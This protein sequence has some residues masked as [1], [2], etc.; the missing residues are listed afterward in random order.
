VILKHK[1][2]T[3]LDCAF[4]ALA[5]PTQRAEESKQETL[6]KQAEIDEQ[7]IAARAAM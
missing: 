1:Y 7:K 6:A 2:S 4:Q 3:P 5:D